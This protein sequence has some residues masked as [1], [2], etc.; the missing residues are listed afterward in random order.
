MELKEH[1]RCPT[2]RNELLKKISM[3]K[4]EIVLAHEKL[5]EVQKK[6]DDLENKNKLEQQGLLNS[7]QIKLNKFGNYPRSKN[8]Q[9]L[10]RKKIL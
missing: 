10:F 6:Y 2:I 5:V 4:E 1:S 3:L 9:K 8:Q 7:Q